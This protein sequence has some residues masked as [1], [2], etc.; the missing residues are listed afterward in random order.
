[1]ITKGLQF[2]YNCEL[3]GWLQGDYPATAQ[4]ADMG[5]NRQ[6]AVHG[7]PHELPLNVPA[8]DWLQ[9]PYDNAEQIGEST[10]V[11]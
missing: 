3:K 1:M 2:G 5:S 6:R 8:R 10:T 11:I 4:R 9:A 7:R